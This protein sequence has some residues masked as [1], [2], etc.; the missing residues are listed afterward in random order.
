MSEELLIRYAQNRMDLKAINDAINALPVD[1][2]GS[3]FAYSKLFEHRQGFYEG[4]Y[5]SHWPGW[6]AAVEHSDECTDDELKLAQ[7]LDKR[8]VVNQECGKIRRAIYHAGAKLIRESSVETNQGE[9]V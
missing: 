6:E 7:Y 3:I 2:Y 5:S 1:E 8:S 4:E 9:H